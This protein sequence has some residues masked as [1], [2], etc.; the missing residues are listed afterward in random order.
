MARLL[1]GRMAFHSTSRSPEI[2]RDP[3]GKLMPACVASRTYRNPDRA[4]L[5]PG[6]AAKKAARKFRRDESEALRYRRLYLA[7]GAEA[8]Q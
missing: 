3:D 6:K 8:T 4:A 1:A 5:H 2:E 7:A